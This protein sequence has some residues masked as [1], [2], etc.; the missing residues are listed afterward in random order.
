MTDV[1]RQSMIDMG[2]SEEQIKA[3]EDN[4]RRGGRFAKGGLTD[5]K[6][7]PTD[8]IFELVTKD[9]KVYENDYSAMQ[10]FKRCLCFR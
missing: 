7:I 1:E 10:F 5:S 3:V 6:Y 2:Y 9:G 8:E 4:P